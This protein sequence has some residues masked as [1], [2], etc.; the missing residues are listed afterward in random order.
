MCN[1]AQV[2]KTPKRPIAAAEFRMLESPSVSRMTIP[3]KLASAA[4]TTSSSSISG[5]KS[6]RRALCRVLSAVIGQSATT[7]VRTNTAAMAANPG[8]HAQREVQQQADQQP[9]DHPDDDRGRQPGRRGRRPSP[10]SPPVFDDALTSNSVVV[11]F[12]GVHPVWSRQGYETRQSSRRSDRGARLREPRR[13]SHPALAPLGVSPPQLLEL[14]AVLG[15]ARLLLD[16]LDQ[17]LALRAA[18]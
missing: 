17:L 18:G 12:D 13:S 5:W 15:L 9:D 4:A 14:A 10:A 11:Q 2:M 1:I 6:S 3:I 16:L 8:Q 7:P